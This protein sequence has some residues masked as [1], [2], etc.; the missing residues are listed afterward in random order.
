[1]KTS[2]RAEFIIY[3]LVILVSLAILLLAVLSP[4]IF[5]AVD[6]VYRGF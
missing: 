3:G 1:M 6:P 4:D 2:T 5:L